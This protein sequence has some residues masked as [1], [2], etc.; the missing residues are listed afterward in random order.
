VRKESKFE[1]KHKKTIA[2]VGREMRCLVRDKARVG[3][4]WCHRKKK[5]GRG[6]VRDRN[7]GGKKRR[8]KKN[9]VNLGDG[10]YKS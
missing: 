3:H 10:Y 9:I 2:K 4:V 8:G 5:K 7:I 6:K 1:R